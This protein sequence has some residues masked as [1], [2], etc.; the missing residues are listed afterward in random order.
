MRV[1]N[2]SPGVRCKKIRGTP[3]VNPCR[4]PPRLTNKQWIILCLRGSGCRLP[5]S[6]WLA[7]WM[8][9]LLAVLLVGW[10]FSG[11]ISFLLSACLYVWLTDWLA[12]W[13]DGLLAGWLVEW[14]G[15]WL[16]VLF[17]GN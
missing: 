9:G 12:A 6:S 5:V 17:L 15:G 1:P 2:Y 11:R 10:L 13:T 14:L 8:S 16:I 7:G 3:V 4:P